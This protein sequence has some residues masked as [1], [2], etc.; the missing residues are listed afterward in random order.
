[1]SKIH[2]EI[3]GQMS[4][5]RTLHPWCCQHLLLGR[6]LN[7]A[8]LKNKLTEHRAVQMSLR[9]VHFPEAKRYNQ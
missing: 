6:D 2:P 1:M 7:A 3:G 5:L 4:Q 8:A 9:I